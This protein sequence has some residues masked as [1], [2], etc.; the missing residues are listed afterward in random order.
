MSVIVSKTITEYIRQENKL[1]F[2]VVNKQTYMD[3]LYCDKSA[4]EMKRR[5]WDVRTR[6]GM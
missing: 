2:F 1:H 6:R 3:M 5:T 4:P